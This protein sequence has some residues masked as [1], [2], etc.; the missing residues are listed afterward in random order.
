[1]K[2]VLLL[3]LVLGEFGLYGQDTLYVDQQAIGTND[4]SSWQNASKDLAATLRAATANDQVWVAKG[5]YYPTNVTFVKSSK[6]HP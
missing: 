5:T 1:M 2:K 6:P 4:G 3:L